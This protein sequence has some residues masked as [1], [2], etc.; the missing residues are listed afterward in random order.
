MR[1]RTSGP[2][3]RRR[4]QLRSFRRSGKR[5][6]AASS[7]P[8]LFSLCCSACPCSVR[9][10]TCLQRQNMVTA[11]APVMLS[12]SPASSKNFRHSFASEGFSSPPGIHSWRQG[13]GG[14]R[15]GQGRWGGAR[16]VGG[17]EGFSRRDE[18]CAKASL[19]PSFPC[20][21]PPTPGPTTALTPPKSPSA[22]SCQGR[23]R[24][25]GRARARRRRPPAHRNRGCRLHEGLF[26]N[27]L[28]PHR[29]GAAPRGDVRV[30]HEQ[31]V[32]VRPDVPR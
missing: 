26:R 17:R 10:R 12:C 24:R 20:L 15:G 28:V 22:C 1:M 32:H 4:S 14:Q 23:A 31:R 18:W 27:P 8:S 19:D 11:R 2:R 21:H 3:A 13:E 6:A 29:V 16:Q 7:V 30:R 25:S 5:R 9:A